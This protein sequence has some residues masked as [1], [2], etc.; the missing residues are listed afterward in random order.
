MRRLAHG[1]VLHLALTLSAVCAQGVDG[2]FLVWRDGVS[3]TWED[4]QGQPDAASPS[5]QG[6]ES[7]MSI[8]LRFSCTNNVPNLGVTAE[9]DRSKSWARPNMPAS[10]LEHEQVHFDIAELYVRKTRREFREVPNPCDNA[11]RVQ[12]I[13][14]QNGD[15]AAKSQEVYDAETFHGTRPEAQAAWARRIGVLLRASTALD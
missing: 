8:A 7:Q 2:D 13:S 1:L 14:S 3:L 4:F 5:Y 12:A 11:S 6:A 9:F 15:L 10:L